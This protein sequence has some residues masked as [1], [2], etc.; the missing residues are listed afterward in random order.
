MQS[1]FKGYMSDDLFDSK[2]WVSFWLF[3]AYMSH[4]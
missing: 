4:V 1:S 3:P 2:S